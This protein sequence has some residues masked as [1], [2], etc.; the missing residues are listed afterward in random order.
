MRNLDYSLLLIFT[1]FVSLLFA[2]PSELQTES[3]SDVET[4][5]QAPIEQPLLSKSKCLI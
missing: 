4:I 5:S 2:H 3:Q 1:V